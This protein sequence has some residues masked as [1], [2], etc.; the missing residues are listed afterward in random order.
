M[1]ARKVTKQER[2]RRG[3]QSESWQNKVQ[4]HGSRGPCCFHSSAS[5]G[6]DC[7]CWVSLCVVIRSRRGSGA[8]GQRALAFSEGSACL[9]ALAPEHMCRRFHTCLLTLVIECSSGRGQTIP[10]LTHT[11]EQAQFNPQSEPQ[12]DA[13]LKH[14]LDHCL[15]TV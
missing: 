3:A 12:H 13:R 4:Q 6:Q 14:I 5:P 11:H 9:P 15:S 8:R 7:S 2:A 10:Q 1:P